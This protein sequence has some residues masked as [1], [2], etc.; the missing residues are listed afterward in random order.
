MILRQLSCRVRGGIFT[1][2]SA[3]TMQRT[4]KR[5]TWFGWKQWSA[6][7]TLS[8]WNVMLTL[9]AHFAFLRQMIFCVFSITGRLPYIVL[10]GRLRDLRKCW[11]TGFFNTVG[12]NLV[13]SHTR[14]ELPL[15]MLK[16]CLPKRDCPR[17][18]VDVSITVTMHN[19][20]SMCP[21][22]YVRVRGDLS[23]N[24]IVLDD[25]SYERLVKTGEV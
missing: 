21:Q 9:S 19:V 10:L 6:L 22:A 4:M 25:C 11:P 5:I 1:A 2:G 17:Y 8:K 14:S 20:T 13:L 12:A 7:E 23:Y 18:F 3:E 15:R 16:V 24:V